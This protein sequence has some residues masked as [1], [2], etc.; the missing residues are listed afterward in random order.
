MTARGAGRRLA[1]TAAGAM[2]A[3]AAGT[4]MAAGAAGAAIGGCAREAP[5]WTRPLLGQR[6]PALIAHLVEACPGP[7]EE[8]RLGT[9]S[10]PLAAAPRVDPGQL[11]CAAPGA[12]FQ[13]RFDWRGRVQA[14][15]L[16]GFADARAAEARF[17]RAI[18]P[19]VAADVRAAIR[20]SIRGTPDMRRTDAYGE[21][22]V[23]GTG[24]LL[25]VRW[26]SRRS[27]DRHVG[28]ELVVPRREEAPR[29]S[30]ATRGSPLGGL[31]PPRIAAWAAACAAPLE[32][33]TPGAGDPSVESTS[34]ARHA[35]SPERW[36]AARR[37]AGS[38]L[39]SCAAARRR[40]GAPI[41]WRVEADRRGRIYR[42]AVLDADAA[43]L[44]ARA[45]AVVAT[46]LP[47]GL[48]AE[49][50]ASIV[51]EPPFRPPVDAATGR[52]ALQVS[53][54][55]D[56]RWGAELVWWVPPSLLPDREAP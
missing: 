9:W 52:L 53:R 11:D 45:A 6:S 39:L 24:G 17:D 15:E 20:A 47:R 51:R 50:E 8:L 32:L 5:P 49:A 25:K 37:P 38:Q 16:R 36:H 13:V 40:G 41:G 34:H 3:M 30:A 27:D 31:S 42:I 54:A 26:P 1:A 10:S 29:G 48:R 23:P 55:A 14:I 4:A 43:A 56:P 35:A 2:A 21:G 33:R 22:T 12:D 44:R 7:L 28:W 18:A 46:H 19:I